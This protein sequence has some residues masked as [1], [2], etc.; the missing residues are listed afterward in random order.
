MLQTLTNDGD[1]T[2]IN[3]EKQQLNSSTNQT[4]NTTNST[5]LAS[6]L[7]SPNSLIINEESPPSLSSVSSPSSVS[8]SGSPHSSFKSTSR[9]ASPASSNTS[10]NSN[11]KKIENSNDDDL[12]VNPSID[13][14]DLETKQ[15]VI[16]DQDKPIKR[17]RS[18][19]DPDERLVTNKKQ[20][21]EPK[22]EQPLVTQ[23]DE[24]KTALQQ[25][26]DKYEAMQPRLKKFLKIY[27]L[28]SR[29]SLNGP[30]Q[31]DIENSLNSNTVSVPNQE[32]EQSVENIQ[33][34][35]QQQQTESN[36][37][38]RF[39][40]NEH[41]NLSIIAN[42][43]AAAAAAHQKQIE[44]NKQLNICHPSNSAI[45]INSHH[46]HRHHNHPHKRAKYS[47]NQQP[48]TVLKTNESTATSSRS[49]SVGLNG[50]LN[51]EQ[52]RNS[53]NYLKCIQADLNT[54]P[55][56]ETLL[57][58]ERI[59]CFIV[60]GE[61]RLCLH[62]I[63]NT[64]LKEFSVQQINSAC[65]KLQIACLESSS[66]QLDILKKSHLL[67]S[68]A[69]NCGLLT[70]TN[71]ERLCAYLMDSNLS[72]PGPPPPQS[73]SSPCS[74]PSQSSP[75]KKNTLKVVHECFGKTYGHIHMHMY[76]RS[77]AAC[78]E[79]DQCRKLYT[80][81]NFVCHTHKYESNTRHWG[82]DSSNWRVYLK[83]VNNNNNSSAQAVAQ[84]SQ[85]NSKVTN[86]VLSDIK[87]SNKDNIAA[88]SSKLNIINEEF[89]QF[90]KKFLNNNA[91]QYQANEMLKRKSFCES[92]YDL[93]SHKNNT[94]SSENS[95]NTQK[96]LLNQSCSLN[97]LNNH[98]ITTLSSSNSGS[99][100]PHQQLKSNQNTT[101]SINDSKL[102]SSI[103][104]HK[105]LNGL[106]SKPLNGSTNS[107][108]TNLHSLPMNQ[109]QNLL[110]PTGSV[111]HLLKVNKLNNQRP[112][113]TQQIPKYLT[114][115]D[116]NKSTN[117]SSLLFY[118][119]LNSTNKPS[120]NSTN[121]KEMPPR[122]SNSIE[123]NMLEIILHEIDSCVENKESA[124]RL[125]QMVTQL[126]IY[127]TDRLN[128]SQINKNKLL[129]EFDEVIKKNFF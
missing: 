93:K 122:N 89:E 121:T 33:Q 91:N 59:S 117:P 110:I 128:E 96:R 28:S 70:Q 115:E 38:N 26:N 100:S 92:D 118:N 72:I 2:R 58:G 123:I 9:S 1:E 74:S 90:K 83:L 126:Q 107:S 49:N 5:N 114:N 8:L 25:Q 98:L 24:V 47:L 116:F 63:L 52:P 88:N 30:T 45:L 120:H 86:G 31:N 12:K 76:S 4:D 19:S 108:E 18:H 85:T 69:P 80:P 104:E 101:N 50:P 43:A 73:N 6:S 82:F 95:F 16:N 10:T 37:S 36:E 94:H 32:I 102:K 65:Q 109:T 15:A 35:Q 39:N 44:N 105:L 11:N 51:R 68:G 56:I 119:L 106:L 3:N 103:G 27:Q 125:R 20:E 23:T 99:T 22:L 113:L 71:A 64:I 84:D 14:D 62:D 129:A 42:V 40:E 17:S 29:N 41:N 53:A 112:F 57:H 60:G 75:S 48:N 34:K 124:E 46:N 66:K 111:D 87:I 13:H 55:L 61:K 77:D 67:P 81:K 97:D 7:S 54:S 21:I 79:C 78:V 127:F